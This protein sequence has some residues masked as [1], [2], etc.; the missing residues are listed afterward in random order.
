[1]GAGVQEGAPRSPE[2]GFWDLG[3]FV[4]HRCPGC[5]VPPAPPLTLSQRWTLL[6]VGD[7][8]LSFWEV[9]QGIPSFSS[10]PVSCVE[11]CK[12][13]ARQPVGRPRRSVWL[14]LLVLR[15]RGLPCRPTTPQDARSS[16]MERKVTQLEGLGFTLAL[17]RGTSGILFPPCPPWHRCDH[18]GIPRVST[19]LQPPP[20]QGGTSP[21]YPSFPE[22]GGMGLPRDGSERWPGLAWPGLG[23]SVLPSGTSWQRPCGVGGA[24]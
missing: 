24:G 1:M 21:T 7:S 13:S 15:P 17:V 10:C 9:G 11:L 20:A 8:F 19:A 4:P 3:P 12:D 6:A 22:T 5:W 18:E 2:A 14:P 23:R 16:T